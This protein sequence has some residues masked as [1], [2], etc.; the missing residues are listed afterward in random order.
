MA[1][2]V[3]AKVFSKFNLKMGYNQLC[4][5]PEDVWKTTFMTPNGPYMM[6]V[7]TFGFANAPAYF[8]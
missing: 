8:Q 6:L 1:W 7:L 4:I 3:T 2:S 5:K